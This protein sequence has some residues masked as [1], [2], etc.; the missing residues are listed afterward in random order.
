M[1]RIILRASVPS[2]IKRTVTLLRCVLIFQKEI[3][4]NRLTSLKFGS[5]LFISIAVSFVWLGI[6]N[7]QLAAAASSQTHDLVPVD[8]ADISPYRTN[9]TAQ[10]YVMHQMWPGQDL[11]TFSAAQISVYRWNAMATYYL[12]SPARDLT[13]LNAADISAFRWNAM[14]QYYADHQDLPSNKVL[15]IFAATD[16]SDYRFFMI[17][18]GFWT[19]QAS[20]AN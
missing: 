1:A 19:R 16:V 6:G 10:Y 5:I 18:P 15:N 13:T 12:G 20:P 14:A 4:M 11:T 2:F 8:A 3:K 9:S 17:E 7:L